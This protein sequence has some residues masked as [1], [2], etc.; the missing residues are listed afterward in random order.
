MLFTVAAS[1]LLL[2]AALAEAQAAKILKYAHF[3]P[4]KMDQPKHAA[5][6]AFKN[7]VEAATGGSIEVQIYPAGQFGGDAPTMEA[8]RM[9]TLELAVAHDGAIAGTFKPVIALGIPYLFDDQAEA[10]AVLDGP[11]GRE[12]GKQMLAKTGIRFF[13][14]ADNG[15]R[16]FTNSKRPIKSPDDL[17]GLKIRIQP[18]PVF[19]KLIDSLG[20]SASSIPWAQLPTALQ[21]G[22]VDGEENSVTNI[23]A[24]SLY[25]SQKYITLDAHVYSVHAYLMNDRFYQSLTDRE[26]EIVRRGIEIAREIHRGMTTAQDLNAKDIL[27]E[28]GMT[29]DTLTPAQVDAFRQRSQAPVRAYVEKE[30]DKALVDLLFASIE[31]YR[32]SGKAE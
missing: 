20:A 8:L 27:T 16:H 26:K 10:W 32:H 9:G 1:A 18:S 22:I 7:Y 14:F 11:F 12:F 5:A 13:G 30:T 15:L 24:A 25:Q 31:K 28:V 4:A 17:K 3:Q 23:L 19:E 2:T 29:V 6:V 21:E